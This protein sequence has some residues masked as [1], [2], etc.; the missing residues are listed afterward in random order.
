VNYKYT[1]RRQRGWLTIESLAFGLAYAASLCWASVCLLASFR[2]NY[3]N[4]P[5]WSG[6]PGLR[7]DTAG[8]LTFYSSAI[9]FVFSE[10]LRLSRR[11]AGTG[12]AASPAFGSL[13]NA[14]ALAA[15]ETIGLLSTGVVIYLSINTVTHPATMS[16]Q[17][18]HLMPWPTEG[19]L[20]VIA[21]VMCMCSFALIRFLRVEHKT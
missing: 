1:F 6:V 2:P 17:A 7:A 10:F 4:A 11:Q 8:I 5:Y 14:A 19:T 9:F 12:V 3:L 16:K 20:R 21:L 13:M 15:F 18:T